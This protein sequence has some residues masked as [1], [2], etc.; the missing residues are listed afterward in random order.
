LSS[1]FKVADPWARNRR[2]GIIKSFN[3][4]ERDFCVI[5]EEKTSGRSTE[6]VYKVLRLG[7]DD[8]KEWLGYIRFKGFDGSG[9]IEITNRR[10]RS[11]PSTS[12]S[13]ERAKPATHTRPAPT[14][15]G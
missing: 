11:S 7:P 1:P 4:A 6:I 15:R 13:A 9:T 2:D 10:P 8:T 12:T 3:L 14:A 5:H